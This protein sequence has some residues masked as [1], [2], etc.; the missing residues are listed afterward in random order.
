MP[1]N[2]EQWVGQNS[3][4]GQI[5]FYNV[6]LPFLLLF[7]IIYGILSMINLFGDKTKGKKI[8]SLIA[9]I[10]ALFITYTTRYLAWFAS[11]VSNLTGFLGIILLALLFFF[12]LYH[13]ATG[14]NARDIFSSGKIKW[15]VLVIV[16][17]IIYLLFSKSGGLAFFGIFG[18]L[19]PHI[20][21]S[22]QSII[23]F[24]IVAGLIFLVIWAIFGDKS[25]SGENN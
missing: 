15:I 22:V 21:I 3:A 18:N 20:P 6:L 17:I 24:I 4:L 16:A 19:A 1:F 8:N 7:V 14:K 5:G 11:I 25:S 12:M 2:F 13:F 10:L 23:M 9:L